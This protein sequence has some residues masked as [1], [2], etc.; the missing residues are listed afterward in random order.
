MYIQSH[1]AIFK[2]NCRNPDLPPVPP[3]GQSRQTSVSLT[4]ETET[5]TTPLIPPINSDDISSQAQD[6]LASPTEEKRI[7]EVVQPTGVLQT[8]QVPAPPETETTATV[9]WH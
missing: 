4:H 9:S 7:I 1:Q 5:E 6:N 2:A 3:T 8:L